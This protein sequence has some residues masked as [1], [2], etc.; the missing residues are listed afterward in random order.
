MQFTTKLLE[1][2]GQI[3]SMILKS[4]LSDTKKYMTNASKKL[5]PEIK[6]I[7]QKGFLS[8]VEY[9]SLVAGALK[10]EFGLPDASSRV[11][12]IL[13]IW[14]NTTVNFVPPKI[15]GS[16]IYSSLRI[17]MIPADYNDV[18]SLSVSKVQTNKGQELPWLEWLLLFG[19][20]T[21]IK[22]Y[23]IYIGSNPESRTGG[24][25]MKK[26]VGGKWKVPSQFSGSSKNNWVTRVLDDVSTQIDKAIE[27]AVKL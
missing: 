20:K 17:S 7:I 11:S 24:A 13:K 21:I 5:E 25:V 12:Q 14:D 16:K 9:N 6:S 8:S 3:I 27:K 23:E 2:D 19:D 26:V 10:Y 4:L 18:L 15:Q 22:D 1:S